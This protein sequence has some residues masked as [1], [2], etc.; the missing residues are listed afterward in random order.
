MP[1]LKVKPGQENVYSKIVSALLEQLW[2]EPRGFDYRSFS[3]DASIALAGSYRACSG[4]AVGTLLKEAARRICEIYNSSQA[5]FCSTLLVDVE[6]L[7]RLL[8]HA[9]SPFMPLEIGLAWHPYL[10]LPYIPASSLKG[11]LRSYMERS[12][13][14]SCGLGVEELLGT[15]ESVSRLVFFDALPVGC[16]RA[17]IEADVL[18]PHYPEVQ[19][20]ID[21]ARVK[22]NPIVFPVVAGGVRFRF[23][24]GVR[25]VDPSTLACL[26]NELSGLLGEAFEYGLGA[27][28]SIGYGSVKVILKSQAGGE[29]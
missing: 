6:T 26:I 19:G 22:P 24:I 1:M 10:N 11:A 28:T 9:R 13:R 25:D 29:C 20:V 15:K 17:L 16:R 23:V 3:K 8:A 12:G 5:F 14:R 4:E 18:T 2:E 7:D 27:K 21:E